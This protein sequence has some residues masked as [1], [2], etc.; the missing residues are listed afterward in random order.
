MA[1]VELR[2]VHI[3]YPLFSSNSQ[4]SIFANVA[5]R[6]SFGALGRAS[7]SETFVHALRGLEL[8][9]KDGDRLGIC[10]RNGAGKSTLLKTIAGL[11]WPHEGLRR[12]EGQVSCIINLGAGLEMEKTGF[13]NVAYVGRVFGLDAA[14]RQ[15][16]AEDVAE[17]TELGEY[18]N[19]PVRTYS[20][21]MLLRLS[22]ALASGLPGDILV[23]DEILGAGDAF[24]QRKAAERT[25]ATHKSAKIFVMATHSEETLV[26]Y[27]NRA[28]WIERGRIAFEG[29]PRETWKRYIDQAPSGAQPAA[30]ESVVAA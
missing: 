24:F 3:R 27:C 30:V 8:H 6:A 10:G 4:Q 23:V 2:G 18:L 22:Y 21:G 14:A 17:F 25:R 5:K 20:S 26:E 13:D 15:A 7:R 9:L 19:L 12:V 1:L 11:N 29:D 28:I 16:L